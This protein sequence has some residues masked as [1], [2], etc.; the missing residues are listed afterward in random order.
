MA[1]TQLL[2]SPI[3]PSGT[4]NRLDPPTLSPTLSLHRPIPSSLQAD[5]KEVLDIPSNFSSDNQSSLVHSHVP[6]LWPLQG[7]WPGSGS[8]LVCCGHSCICA[9]NSGVLL[10]NILLTLLAVGL[11][12]YYV[13]Y[14]IH[15]IWVA[16]V[17]LIYIATLYALLRTTWTEPGFLP[18][19]LWINPSAVIRAKEYAP[20]V[21]PL[22]SDSA[23]G[24]GDGATIPIRLKFCDTC[25]VYRPPLTSHCRDCDMCV[26]DYDHHCPWVCNC[27][28][29]RNHRY[30]LQFTL[31][32]TLL[33]T[34]LVSLS[35]Y[36]LATEASHQGS[37]VDAMTVRPAA[38][39]ILFVGGC[40]T[41]TLCCLNAERISL[42]AMH[43]TQKQRAVRRR[44]GQDVHGVR[45]SEESQG[46]THDAGGLL[47]GLHQLW[48]SAQYPS[49]FSHH[50]PS[51]SVQLPSLTNPSDHQPPPS[52]LSSTL[53]SSSSSTTTSASISP[54]VSS[55]PVTAFVRYHPIVVPEE[56]AR[57]FIR[58]VQSH[59]PSHVNAGD[60]AQSV[61]THPQSR[62]VDASQSH[63]NA[64]TS[65][66][67]TSTS[68]AHLL[69]EG[70]YSS[71][72]IVRDGVPQAILSGDLG[73]LYW[74][75]LEMAI[76]DISGT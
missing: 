63:D 20:W 10:C 35:I 39:V 41:L 33:G 69:E 36:Q 72:R 31:L 29:R 28:G 50:P 22:S 49:L 43:L 40:I 30:F 61:V 74:H 52:A 38:V 60:T 59:L 73:L 67:S 46:P 12:S 56:I 37:F 66:H 32:I 45:M 44:M 8:T 48:C 34:T 75:K 21:L 19:R 53:S 42:V 76:H 58:Q 5:E 64:P 68:I 6:E 55:P 26:K 13:A 1:S 4:S 7:D 16:V 3:T 15:P 57:L 70:E 47:H 14:E 62:N 17:A 27:V 23:L 2:S 65:V 11:G 71:M 25:G 9:P 54:N 24:L 18:A 51:S